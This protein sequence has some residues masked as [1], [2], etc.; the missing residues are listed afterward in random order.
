MAMKEITTILPNNRNTK[1]CLIINQEDWLRAAKELSP[2]TFA[3]YLYFA[4]CVDGLRLMFSP[5]VVMLKLGIS[6]SSIKRGMKQLVEKGYL[7]AESDDNIEY[8][9]YVSPNN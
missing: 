2:T 6:D 1:D 5:A 3:L 4:S 8:T 7:V 9:F